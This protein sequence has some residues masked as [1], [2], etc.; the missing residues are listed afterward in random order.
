MITITEPTNFERVKVDDIIDIKQ[1][2]CGVYFIENN[3]REIIYI[4]KTNSFRRRLREH[5]RDSFF[6]AHIDAVRLYDVK[7]ELSRELYETY[8][9]NKYKPY[10]NVGKVYESPSESASTVEYHEAQAELNVLMDEYRELREYFRERDADGYENEYDDYFD[11]DN[12]RI[13]TLGDDLYAV[14]RLAE[15]GAEISKAKGR[16]STIRHKIF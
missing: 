9:I 7:D 8:L 5:V 4:G 2:R 15:L 14:E 6:S 12:K 11:D 13:Y 16:V 3:N 1:G 10:Y